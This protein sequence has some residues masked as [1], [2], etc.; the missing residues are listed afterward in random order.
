MKYSLLIIFFSIG[1]KDLCAQN[2]I[3]LNTPFYWLKDASSKA[4]SKDSSGTFLSLKKAVNAGLYDVQ[5]ISNNKKYN[6]ILS[7]SQKKEIED[8][9]QANR[10]KIESPSSIKVVTN[11]ID[12]FWKLYPSINDSDA[13]NT[14]LK[15]YIGKGSTGLQTFFQIRMN[16]NLQYFI[17]SIRQKQSYYRSIKDVSKQFKTMRPQFVNAAKKLETLYP[18]SIFPPIYFLVG[19]LNNAGTAD[20][21]S[22]LLI[23]T[24]HLGK[25]PGADTSQLTMID[26]LVLFDTSL[27]VRLIVHEYVHFQQKNKQEQT[28][29]E[30]SIMEGVADFITYLIT[31]K[32]TAP[33]VYKYG[34]ANEGAIWKDFSDEMNSENTDKWLFN[35]YNSQT[36]YPG[37]LGYFIGFRICESYY[38][39]SVNKQNAVKELFEIKEFN[40]F[41]IQSDYRVE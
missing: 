41:L 17:N 13:V 21:F 16:S 5:V 4:A 40:Q 8:G 36:G 1:F 32:Y 3:Q 39:Q 7:T 23:G 22:G 34:F 31:G 19:N 29:L 14:F 11:D 33:E 27:A 10:I 12:N 28:L 6:T 18:E 2:P 9:I 30:Y 37:N 38:R 26:K 35:T 25:H 15:D 20:G 24:E